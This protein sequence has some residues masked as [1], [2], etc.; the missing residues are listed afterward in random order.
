MPDLVTNT[1]IV[2]YWLGIFLTFCI[3]SFLYKDNPFYKLAEHLYVGVSIGYLVVQQYFDVIHTYLVEKLGNG[4][5][6]AIVP[7]V[8]CLM[9]FTKAV[10]RRFSWVARYPLALVVALYAGFAIKTVQADLGA[11]VKDATQSLDH[12]KL[13]INTATPEELAA[14]PGISGPVAEKI[15]ARR[16]TAPFASVDEIAGL[17]GL[18]EGQKTGIAEERGPF[19]GLDAKASTEDG[20]RDYFGILSQV[21]LLMGL[22]S[23]LVYFYFSIE[24]K[25]PVKKVSRFGVWI[26]MIGFGASFGYTV[27]GRLSL[28]IGRAMD[29]LGKDKDPV[30][31]ER[32]HGPLVALVSIA[33]IVIGIALWEMKLRRV[34][35]KTS[36]SG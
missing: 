16:A 19:I 17:P 27:Q 34:Q 18:T 23:S 9:L 35:A 22:I 4:S 15:V 8:L 32:I 10:S 26:L 21:L 12:P 11:Q 28:A 33:V 14:L 5:L 36:T 29:V 3:L 13:N 2:G 31:A 24:Q 25:G 30:L 1:E 7:L 20:A 6:L